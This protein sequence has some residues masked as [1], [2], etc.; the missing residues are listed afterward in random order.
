MNSLY[1]LNNQKYV[2]DSKEYEIIRIKRLYY[3]HKIYENYINMLKMEHVNNLQISN[4]KNEIINKNKSKMK[5]VKNKKNQTE[6]K[7]KIT[8][9]KRN[10]IPKN[11]D[12]QAKINSE[13]YNLVN[14]KKD[15]PEVDIEKIDINPD[16]NCFYRCLS[17][18][19]LLNEEFYLEIKHIIIE[20]IENN[21]DK[22]INFFWDDEENNLTKEELA[23]KEFNY[24]KTNNSWGSD[25]T[26]I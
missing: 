14:Q 15:I 22:F 5:E 3:R 17:Y 20:W 11:N 8:Q 25:Y 18:F 19:F 16:G 9:N 26:F 21:Y 10:Q 24:I 1:I 2:D 23:K 7:S 6:I 12:S 13:L 4:S